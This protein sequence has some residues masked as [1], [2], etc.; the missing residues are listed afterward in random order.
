MIKREWLNRFKIENY[1]QAYMLVFEYI[2]TFY[3]TVRIHSHCNYM[4]PNDYEK[5]Y[6]QLESI[7]NLAGVYKF[8][9]DTKTRNKLVLQYLRHLD[10]DGMDFNYLYGFIDND[11]VSYVNSNA[12]NEEYL[13][14]ENIL[15][16]DS[17]SEKIKISHL[18]A[19][20]NGYLHGWFTA[21]WGKEQNAL[22]CWA[23][24]LV[25]MGL[26]R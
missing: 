10:Y 11:F 16:P 12:P 5:L 13:N 4:S 24:D 25:Q 17:V 18:A 22:G 9:A 14:P 21:L 8:G 6:D 26:R 7:Y 19:S 2:N 23:G 20:L 15:V 1:Q 3:N